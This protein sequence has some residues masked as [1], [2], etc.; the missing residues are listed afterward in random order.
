MTAFQ[1]SP[2]SGDYVVGKGRLFVKVSGATQFQEVGDVDDF[3]M[4]Q[5]NTL[6]ERFSNQYGARTKTDS[7][8]TQQNAS[9]S[10]TCLQGTARNLALALMSDKT[11]LTQSLGTSSLGTFT[12]VQVGDVID[13]GKLNISVQTLADHTTAA[14]PWVADTNYKLD[15]A[16]GTLKI[17]ALVTAATS[18]DLTVNYPAIAASTHQLL[19]GLGQNPSLTAEL[20]FIALN[21]SSVPIEKYTF[22]SVKLSPD[23]DVGLIGDDYRNFKIKGEIIA[24]STQATGYTLGKLQ[25][26]VASTNY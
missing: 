8:I 24:D 7:R 25:Q 1:L 17:L 22:W 12:S 15:S 26:L 6:L 13:T 23:G 19:A 3:S 2:I 11:A 5:D 4:S 14:D 16:S 21:E 20:V 10:F 9:L 18:V